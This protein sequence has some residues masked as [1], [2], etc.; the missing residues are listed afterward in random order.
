M[1]GL[2]QGKAQGGAGESVILQSWSSICLVCIFVASYWAAKPC[3]DTLAQDGQP[4]GA[5]P[6]NLAAVTGIS[7]RN[8]MLSLS[9]GYL[10]MEK[11]PRWLC[12][13]N[14]KPAVYQHDHCLAQSPGRAEVQSWNIKKHC[15]GLCVVPVFSP[16]RTRSVPLDCTR[17]RNYHSHGKDRGI[18][19]NYIKQWKDL[20]C[21]CLFR[22]SWHTQNKG[23][24]A[25]AIPERNC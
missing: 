24:L 16:F 11:K 25:A 18:P 8:A 5:T 10:K 19:L 21:N 13:L 15:R 3:S 22:S 6:A 17:A 23:I 2:R 7:E 12:S 20:N 14:L 1:D 9:V 4:A